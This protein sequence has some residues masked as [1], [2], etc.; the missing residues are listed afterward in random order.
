MNEYRV[1]GGK[2]IYPEWFKRRDFLKDS[3]LC[4]VR[5]REHI[6]KVID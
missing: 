5:I 1:T 4:G 2:R 6:R 3:L